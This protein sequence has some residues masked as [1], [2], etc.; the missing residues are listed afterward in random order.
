MSKIILITYVSKGQ[1]IVSHGVNDET[2]ENIIL[3]P[4]PV[5]TFDAIYDKSFD[6]LVMED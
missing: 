4:L 2:L 1:T 5:E 6:A 3:P